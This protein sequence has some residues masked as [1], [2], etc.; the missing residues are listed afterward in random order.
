MLL[1]SNG[2]RGWY[3]KFVDLLAKEPTGKFSVGNI[4]TKHPF[5]IA[6]EQ[7]ARVSACIDRS[8]FVKIQK[9]VEMGFVKAKVYHIPDF[10]ENFGQQ[11]VSHV[12][13]SIT[14]RGWIYMSDMRTQ[15]PFH[16]V[17]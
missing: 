16:S 6:V 3:N 17:H 7:R 11:G 14:L 4:N 12:P 5:A 13:P 2:L 1:V 10:L 15:A 9:D 8:H